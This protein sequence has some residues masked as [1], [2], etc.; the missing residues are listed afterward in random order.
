MFKKSF[1]SRFNS[2]L[3]EG[4]IMQPNKSID[5]Q[6]QRPGSNSPSC[7][8]VLLPVTSSQC[9]KELQKEKEEVRVGLE[10]ALKRLE[11]QHKE[12]LVQ[13]EDRCGIHFC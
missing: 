12:E 9:C 11:E 7:S 8:L 10:E 1:N 13:L 5:F 3:Y 6:A 2:T 4:D